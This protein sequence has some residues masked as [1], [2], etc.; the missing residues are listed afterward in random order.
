VKENFL[1]AQLVGH[2]TARLTDDARRNNKMSG[3]L[4][5]GA[6]CNMTLSRPD[7]EMR[8][9]NSLTDQ[10]SPSSNR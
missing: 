8:G 1:P 5:V 2:R 6:A 10:H 3:N 9:H 7:V 4:R